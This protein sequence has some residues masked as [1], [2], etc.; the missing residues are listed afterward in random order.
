VG[1]CQVIYAVLKGLVLSGE[2]GTQCPG[3]GSKEKGHEK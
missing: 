3:D 1:L 2:I